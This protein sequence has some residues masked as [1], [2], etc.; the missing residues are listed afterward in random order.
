[1]KKLILTTLAL[2]ALLSTSGC[3]ILGNR[4]FEDKGTIGQQLI[5]L[6]KAKDSGVITETEFQ[7]QKAKLLGRK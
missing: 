4:S 5:D 7:E 3:L 2:A 1:M 6:Q